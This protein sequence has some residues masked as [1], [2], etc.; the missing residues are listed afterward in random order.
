[1]AAHYSLVARY[2]NA[3]TQESTVV[4]KRILITVPI[5][6]SWTE[7]EQKASFGPELDKKHAKL[8]DNKR[9]KCDGD[10]K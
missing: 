1:V 4:F 3:I 7:M 6:Q 9:G 8:I 2:N 5:A 10:N